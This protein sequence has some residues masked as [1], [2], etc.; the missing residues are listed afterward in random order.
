M[1]LS[2]NNHFIP[3]MYLNNWTTKNGEIY[4]YRL[5]VSDERVP[6]WSKK[7]VSRTGSHT[8]LYVRTQDGNQIDDFE[9]DFDRRFESPAREALE[10]AVSL[11]KLTSDDWHRLTDFV[12]AL[13]VRTPAFYLYSKDLGMKVI[14]DVLEEV[15]KELETLSEDTI[16]K[17]GSTVENDSDLI[18]ISLAKMP[19][20]PDTEHTV[21][22]IN[23]IV[24]KNTWLFFM[25][26]SLEENSCLRKCVGSMKW[27]IVTA[28]ES[29]R[30]P[31]TDNPVT[32]VQEIGNNQYSIIKDGLLGKNVFLLIPISPKRALIASQIR[33][34]DFRFTASEELSLAFKKLIINNA[35]MYVYSDC[36]DEQISSYRK[37]TISIEEY[38]RLEKAFGEWFENYLEHEGP[39][40][41]KRN[42]LIKE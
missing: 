30:W 11:G 29:V 26:H 3:R 33:K 13:Y 37:R 38:K 35:L 1:N 23:T 6:E 22:E 41:E 36:K 16:P 14:P 8:N 19:E 12:C 9:H 15:C 42:R 40:L 31:S 17:I 25:K 7:P 20:K 10:K 5:L 24:G 34:F 4:T 21:L 2:R 27:S 32:I 39:L 28:S 18:P